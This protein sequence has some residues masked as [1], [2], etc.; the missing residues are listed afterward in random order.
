MYVCVCLA[1]PQ[2]EVERA[3]REGA[4][5][6]EA[7]TRACKAG[8]DC[9]ACHGMIHT[10]IEDHLEADG[11]GVRRSCP[12]VVATT[13]DGLVPEQALVRTRAA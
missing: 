5:T 4:H 12:P 8:G 2:S 7:V 6:R 3:I 11:T 9:G 13:A 1:V 10:M